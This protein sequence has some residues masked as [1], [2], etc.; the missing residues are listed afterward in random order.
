M[1]KRIVFA[2]FFILLA[3]PLVYGDRD[4][5]MLP[6]EGL[7]LPEGNPPDGKKAFER[8]KCN[9]CHWVQNELDFS[10]PVAAK[11]GPIL[12]TEQ[13]NYAPGWI[14][15]SIISPSH[16]LAVNWNGEADGSE[17]S[18]MGDFRETMTVRELFDIVAYI[19]SLKT[20]E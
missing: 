9:A 19:E 7:F 20:K 12:G 5:G 2:V 16:T 11:V 14:A 8:L 17:L 10:A 15:N 1:T 3:G 6:A 13:A 18:R 4:Q